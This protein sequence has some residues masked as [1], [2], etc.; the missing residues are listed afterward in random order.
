MGKNDAWVIKKVSDTFLMLAALSLGM[1]GQ[2][3]GLGA[4]LEAVHG[5][6]DILIR[7]QAVGAKK[8]SDSVARAGAI[9]LPGDHI[10]TGSE[11]SASVRYE[12]GAALEVARSSDFKIEE[13]TCQLYLYT[14]MPTMQMRP[15]NKQMKSIFVVKTNTCHNLFVKRSQMEA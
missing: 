12:S 11:N 6:G 10:V 13:I 14:I 3:E 2:T 8:A 7:R 5:K 15:M 9:L 4:V 1:V